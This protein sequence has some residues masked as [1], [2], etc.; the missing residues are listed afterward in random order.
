MKALETSVETKGK[1]TKV[2]IIGYWIVT[3]LLLMCLLTGGITDIMQVQ[4]NKEGII[5][6]GFPVYV[7]TILGVWKILGAIVIAVPGLLLVKEWAYA[8]VFFVMSGAFISHLVCGD[9]IGV[10]IWPLLFAILT[11]IS[12]VL[13]PVTKSLV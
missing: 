7:L 13:R 5:H 12:W 3:I 1:T 8:G 4:V 2:K 11:I 6:L 9:S 10:Y